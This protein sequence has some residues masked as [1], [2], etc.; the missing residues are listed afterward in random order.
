MNEKAEFA[1]E[2]LKQYALENQVST[3][4]TSDL[5]PLEQWLILRLFAVS[6]QSEKLLCGDLIKHN[7]SLSKIGVCYECKSI[8]DRTK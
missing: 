7:F 5:S 3:R 8:K 2:I 6:E 4:S 1:V